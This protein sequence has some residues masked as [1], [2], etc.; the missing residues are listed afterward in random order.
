VLV[1]CAF[2]I[3]PSHV[4][5]GLKC[6]RF[7]GVLADRRGSNL[8][9]TAHGSFA[10]EARRLGRLTCVRHKAINGK[11]LAGAFPD[12]C[13]TVRTVP[14][15]RETYNHRYQ[16]SNPGCGKI[17]SNTVD[18]PRFKDA[19][20]RLSRLAFTWRAARRTSTDWSRGTAS[21]AV[22]TVS[23]IRPSPSWRRE[24]KDMTFRNLRKR[25]SYFRCRRTAGAG[26]QGSVLLRRSAPEQETNA[27]VA[28]FHVILR[29]GR[30]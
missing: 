12:L 22:S 29:H 25:I 2:S 21:G 18:T 28:D 24:S 4:A 30:A 26:A 8:H 23:D 5:V 19:M 10:S 6:N 14:L 15:P 13:A 1:F 11:I 7:F 9:Q 17:L 16:K 27:V 20:I 3:F